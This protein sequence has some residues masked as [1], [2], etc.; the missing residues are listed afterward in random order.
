M[1]AGLL[2]LAIGVV[3]GALMAAAGFG[4]AT[5]LD[6]NQQGWVAFGIALPISV[7]LLDAWGR[8]RESRRVVV[9]ARLHASGPPYARAAVEVLRG[10]KASDDPDYQVWELLALACFY[11]AKMIYNLGDDSSAYNLQWRVGRAVQDLLERGPISDAYLADIDRL[12]PD[13]LCGRKARTWRATLKRNPDG[14]LYLHTR[15]GWRHHYEI[16]PVTVLALLDHIH[17]KLD[18][19]WRGYLGVALTTMLFY[20]QEHGHNDPL[21]V[22]KAPDLALNTVSASVLE[23]QGREP[24]GFEE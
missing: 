8:S 16:T 18:G 24:S 21:S 20:Y 19:Y 6:V 15:V 12:T 4:D 22:A 23:A 14:S 9:E 5:G 7:G 3:T 17:R 2:A 13:S 1:K 11:F 10:P